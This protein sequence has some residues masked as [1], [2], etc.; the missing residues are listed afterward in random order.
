MKQCKK[1][2]YKIEDNIWLDNRVV[3]C[4]V[5]ITFALFVA[6]CIK[7]TKQEVP[8]NQSSAVQQNA[9][10]IKQDSKQESILQENKKISYSENLKQIEKYQA[11]YW[12]IIKRNNLLINQ[13]ME[14]DGAIEKDGKD[15]LNLYNIVENS[16]DKGNQ[17][18]KK[19]AIIEKQ[20]EDDTS[21]TQY[22]M[23]NYA[24]I[25]NDT[26][27]GLLNDVYKDI[28]ATIPE[29]DFTNLKL[30]ER[31]WLKDIESYKTVMNSEELG[32]MGS[33]TKTYAIADMRKFRILLLLLYY[34]N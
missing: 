7:A 30:S 28:K 22:D 29:N 12:E 32:S 4:V 33:M 10:E 27:D 16:I 1:C 20:R 13:N 6:F 5:L 34:N 11:K 2:G 14:E 31:K 24:G 23:N 17:F 15:L 9:K 3:G 21:E 18:Y 19:L 26:I 25:Y 8:T